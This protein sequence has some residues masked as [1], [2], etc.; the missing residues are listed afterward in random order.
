MEIRNTFTVPLPPEEAWPLLLDVER[1]APCLPGTTYE[2]KDE[3][4]TFRATVSVR[5]G[6][7][8]LSFRGKARFVEVDEAARRAVVKADGRD[9]KGRGDAAATATFVVAADEAGSRVSVA[10][11][12]SLTGTVAQYGRAKGMI[13][14]VAQQLV[15]AFADNLAADLAATRAAPATADEGAPTV[16]DALAAGPPATS[17][18]DEAAAPAAEGSEAAEGARAE[19]AAPRAPGGARGGRPAGAATPISGLRVLL[20]ALAGWLGRLFG[21][22]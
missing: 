18:G 11:D 9:T 3:D 20:A 7:V 5:L 12:L 2:G 8:T 6:P 15:A 10:T 19:A 1:I 16:A 14:S 22:R 17:P 21:R 4:G 13:E